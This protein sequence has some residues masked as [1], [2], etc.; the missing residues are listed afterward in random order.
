LGNNRKNDNGEMQHRIFGQFEVRR[1]EC[2]N[3]AGCFAPPIVI[4]KTVRA[5]EDLNMG[6]GQVFFYLFIYLFLH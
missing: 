3:A 2:V 6:H 1:E 5:W 4:Y